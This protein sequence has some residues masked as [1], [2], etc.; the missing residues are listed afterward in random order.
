MTAPSNVIAYS[1][2]GKAVKDSAA[3]L[4]VIHNAN[5]TAQVVK[6]P[7]AGKWSILVSGEKAGT[8]AISAG[9]MTQVTVPAQSTMVLSQ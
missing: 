6:L 4:V 1:I 2:A 7:K 5:A 8:K 3:N 9:S